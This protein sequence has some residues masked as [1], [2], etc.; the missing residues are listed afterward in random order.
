VV[1]GQFPGLEVAADEQVMAPGRR[2]RARP[3][4]TSARPWSRGAPC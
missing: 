4:R 3:R 2:R 1:E